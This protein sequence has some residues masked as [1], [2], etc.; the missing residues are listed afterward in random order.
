MWKCS[1]NHISY[2]RLSPYQADFGNADPQ[3]LPRNA[4]K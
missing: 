1:H 2:S 4:Q 3:P